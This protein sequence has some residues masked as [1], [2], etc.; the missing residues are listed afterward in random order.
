MG[1]MST[2]Y[3]SASTLVP[4]AVQIVI[5]CMENN[6]GRPDDAPAIFRQVYQSLAEAVV[7][8]DAIPA[9]SLSADHE[10]DLDAMIQD[11]GSKVRQAALPGATSVVHT[12]QL[13]SPSSAAPKRQVALSAPT[14]PNPVSAP[15][16]EPRLPRNLRDVGSALQMQSIVCLED[17]KKV[18]NLAHHLSK[19]GMTPAQYRKKWGLPAEYP[20][21][22]PK[23][24][25][26]KAPVF[27][28]DFVTGKMTAV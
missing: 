11:L 22:A 19:I 4:Q 18:R 27:E 23:T 16:S 24:L 28:V 20:M 12:A 13:R 15:S 25:L 26:K 21:Q 8:V 17:G 14:K 3:T 1:Q 2:D 6:R 7:A 5:G 10:L 9:P